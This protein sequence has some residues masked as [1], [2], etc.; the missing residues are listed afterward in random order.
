MSDYSYKYQVSGTS[1]GSFSYSDGWGSSYAGN[2][3]YIRA[4][5][6]NSQGTTYGAIK[7]ITIPNAP[8]I[9]WSSTANESPYYYS[10]NVG[11]YNINLKTNCTSYGASYLSSSHLTERGLIFTSI[12]TFNN[13]CQ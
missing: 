11:K 7:T 3:Y 9:T 6:T 1:E 2:T 8:S 4:Y 13:L 12:G 10:A 5:V